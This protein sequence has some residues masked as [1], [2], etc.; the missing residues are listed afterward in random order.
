MPNFN[1]IHQKQIMYAC[2]QTPRSS[3]SNVLAQH[4]PASKRG[5]CRRAVSVRPSRSFIVSKLETAIVATEVEYGPKQHQFFQPAVSS[6]IKNRMEKV[7]LNMWVFP[8]PLTFCP[9]Q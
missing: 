8:F 5:R 6:D 7:Q 4:K 1:R 3:E 2:M 9:H